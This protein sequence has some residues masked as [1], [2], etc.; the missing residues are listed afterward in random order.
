MPDPV[1]YRSLYWR[2]AIGFVAV[3]AVLLAAQALVFLWITGRTAGVWPGRSPAEYA[4]LIAADVSMV[5]AEQPTLDLD[6]YL[7]QRYTSPYRSFA[8]VMRDRKVIYGRQ[9]PPSPMIGR[10]ALAQ[11]LGPGFGRGGRAGGRGVSDGPSRG[12]A[13]FV[14]APVRIA[15]ETVAMVAVSDGPPPLSATLS[16]FGPTLAIEALAV[17]LVGAAVVALLVFRP[18][19]RR[20]AELQSAAQAIGSGRADVRAPEEGGDEVAQLARAFN[21]MAGRLEARAQALADA[22]RTRRQLLADISH[23]LATPLAAIRGYVETLG[24]AEV[25]LD[26]ATRQRYLS[27]VSEEAERLE[28]MIGDLLDLA[29][30][31]GSSRTLHPEPVLVSQ[32]FSRVADR[33][34]PVLLERNI[35]LHVELADPAL[36]VECEAPRL[37]Q[38]LQNLASNAVR[39]TPAGGHL[40]MCGRADDDA[41]VLVVEDSGPGIPEEH[42]GRVFDRFYKVDVSRTGTSLP[43]GTGLGLSIVQAIVLQHHGTVRVS[44]APGA[45]ARLEIRLPLVH[46]PSADL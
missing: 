5:M 29:K 39:H 22:D 13:A 11:L 41:V 8:V 20:L 18:A 6:T 19:R 7:N 37:E 25:T 42:L 15:D 36:M 4:Q 34:A 38:A 16:Q 24:M 10:A 40:R 30:L 17:L 23:E 44:N 12:A 2:I 28:Q 1:W 31:E 35:T 27:I 32:L 45:G 43:S 3:L 14:F 46:P 26:A 21:E 33:H 9:V